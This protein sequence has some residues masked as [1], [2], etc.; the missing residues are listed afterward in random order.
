MAGQSTLGDRWSAIGRIVDAKV[1]D[2]HPGNIDT[3][4]RLDHIE[5]H[6]L[7]DKYETNVRFIDALVSRF[8]NARGF[9][10]DYHRHLRHAQD[11]DTLARKQLA[12][13]EL[14]RRLWPSDDDCRR[15]NL[16]GCIP[17]RTQGE[18]A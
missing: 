1:H 17:F 15:P 9:L 5:L 4:A 14:V 6:R 16:H 13:E 3:Q 18:K 2:Q 10:F 12:E 8:T 7:C 11:L